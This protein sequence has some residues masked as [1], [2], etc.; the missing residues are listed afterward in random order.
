MITGGG[1][2][3]VAAIVTI[4]GGGGGALVVATHDMGVARRVGALWRLDRGVLT[5]AAAAWR[6]A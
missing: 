1:G 5:A 4:A 2:A 6:P 3:D